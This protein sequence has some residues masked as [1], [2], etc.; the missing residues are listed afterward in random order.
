MLIFNPG[1]NGNNLPEFSFF[2][3][4]GFAFVTAVSLA[5]LFAPLFYRHW[6]KFIGKWYLFLM[7]IFLLVNSIYLYKS[8][9]E[10]IK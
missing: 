7:V 8:I 9:S 10:L 3:Q 2:K 6:T 1:T 5:V 4:L